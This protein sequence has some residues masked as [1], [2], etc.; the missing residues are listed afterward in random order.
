MNKTRNLAY[1]IM[2]WFFLAWWL[3]FVLLATFGHDRHRP[4]P[5]D[6]LIIIAITAA[7]AFVSFRLACHFLKIGP[8]GAI[9]DTTI[10][11]GVGLINIVAV[12]PPPHGWGT[13]ASGLVSAAMFYQA[14][15]CRREERLT[16][17]H[18]DGA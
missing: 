16:N 2:A 11:V 4:G 9:S 14:F 8:S 3:T 1:T 7:L 13:F 12:I 17:S 6:Y 5:A 15:R 18:E 10:L